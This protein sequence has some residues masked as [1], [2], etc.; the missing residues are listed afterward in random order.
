M[1]RKHA[2]A[3]TKHLFKDLQ[4]PLYL[5]GQEQ[6]SVIKFRDGHGHLANLTVK[7]TNDDLLLKPLDKLVELENSIFSFD[8]TIIVDHNLARHVTNF[9]SNVILFETWSYEG[10]GALDGILI[11]HLLLWIQRFQLARPK[12]L[13]SYRVNN[14]IGQWSLVQEP[15][16]EEYFVLAIAIDESNRLFD[17]WIDNERRLKMVSRWPLKPKP[18]DFKDDCSFFFF[19]QV[20]VDTRAADLLGP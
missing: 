13:H 1:K 4:L 5:L 17:E 10:D 16:K 15:D 20:P 14:V 19:R 7:G 12:S 3:I 9:P 8:N 18:I 11:D 6:C 2:L